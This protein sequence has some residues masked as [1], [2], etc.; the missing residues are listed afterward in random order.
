MKSIRLLALTIALLPCITLADIGGTYSKK[1]AVAELQKQGSS[2]EFLINSSVGQNT[3]ELSG[4]ATMIDK[5][6]AAYTP[7]D[8]SDK[9]SAVLNFSGGHLK[10]TT[11]D[12]ED[13]CGLNASGSMDGQYIREQPRVSE[14]VQLLS[15]D[16]ISKISGAMFESYRYGKVNQMLKDE[17]NCWEDAARQKQVNRSLVAGCATAALAGGFIE[18]T[19]ARSQ[20]RGSHPKYTGESIRERIMANSRLSKDETHSILE[21]SVKPNID[22]ILTGLA[23]A[24]MR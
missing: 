19:Y 21:E 15:P 10:I 14:P 3:C 17:M 23:G 20:G 24:G 11:R 8:K 5:N 1:N 9:C 18:A 7:L 4:V 22:F 16:K 6:R 2:V 13:Y 12:C